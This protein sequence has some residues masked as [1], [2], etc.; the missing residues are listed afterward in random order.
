[1]YAKKHIVPEC[2]R[3]IVTDVHSNCVTAANLPDACIPYLQSGTN[4]AFADI[5]SSWIKMTLL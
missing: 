4:T 1:M 3:P 5:M 2:E